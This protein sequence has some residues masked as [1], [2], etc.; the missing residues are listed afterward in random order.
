[1]VIQPEKRSRCTEPGAVRHRKRTRQPS[2]TPKCHSHPV[3]AI[4]HPKSGN[5]A[6]QLVS[7]YLKMKTVEEAEREGSLFQQSLANRADM[8]T[9]SLEETLKLR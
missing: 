3:G 2:I 5:Q 8:L 9:R 7:E 6:A 4:L 1:M